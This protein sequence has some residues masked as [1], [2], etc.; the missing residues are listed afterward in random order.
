MQ[1][2]IIIMVISIDCACCK[3]IWHLC[4][5]M[6][7]RLVPTT[8]T[9]SSWQWQCSLVTLIACIHIRRSIC[10]DTV[11]DR[12]QDTKHRRKDCIITH[13]GYDHYV[14]NA[15][16]T[17]LIWPLYFGFFLLQVRVNQ[18]KTGSNQKTKNHSITLWMSVVIM[19]CYIQ[20]WRRFGGC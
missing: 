17:W 2:R 19:L 6:Q 20:I 15:P 10:S 9:S 4:I 12:S 1:L 16:C 13:V 11:T 7:P 14:N 3:H 18:S 8:P 5:C